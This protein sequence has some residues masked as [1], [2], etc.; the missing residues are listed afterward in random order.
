[1]FKSP[2]SS[3]GTKKVYTIRNS[4]FEVDLRFDVSKVLGY[5]A[6]GVV[7]AAKDTTTNTHVAI[8]KLGNIFSDMIDGKRMLRE[9]MLLRY[10]SHKNILPLLTILKPREGPSRYQ[11]LYLVTE[12]LETDLH[13]VVKSRQPLTEE[14][15][16]L[17]MYQ[18]VLAVK[19]MH[20]AGV[21]HRDIKPAN[22]LMNSDCTVKLCDF[23]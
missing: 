23:G 19:H 10:L 7:V 1:M 16:Q 4:H 20:S 2:F 12:L 15:L 8:K 17:I 21:I 6:Y 11:D 13:K 14:H 5:G 22:I 9:V 3:E 18:T